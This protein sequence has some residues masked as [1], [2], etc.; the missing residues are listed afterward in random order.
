MFSFKNIDSLRS[1]PTPF[2]YYDL[3]VLEENILE[4]EKH[5]RKHQVKIH[6]AL[7]A[8]NNRPILK[9]MINAGFGA[10]CVSGPEMERAIESGFLPMDIVFAGVGKTDDEIRFGIHNQISCFNCESVH[11]LEIIDQIAGEMNSIA[12]VALRINPDFNGQTHKKITTGT[13]F[14]KFGIPKDEILGTIN[15]LKE[16]KNIKFNGLHFHIGSQIVN[17][18]IFAALAREINQIQDIFIQH[19]LIPPVLNL[20]GGLG[21]DY[22]LP[23]SN[24]IPDYSAFFDAY[25]NNLNR[26]P[27]QEIHFELG[28]SIVAECGSLISKVLFLKKN[29]AATYAIV[30][31]GMNDLMR[32]ALYNAKHKIQNLTGIGL[33]E[34]YHVAG[35]VC[36]SSDVF[37]KDILLP[38]LNRGDLIAI[39]TSGA[40]GEVMASGYNLRKPA[41][42]FYS[43]ELQ[44]LFPQNKVVVL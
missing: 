9:K 31:A 37:R 25:L 13:R 30:D 2:Y 16:L 36:E 42:A 35:P 5:S 44:S 43:K 20:G 32:P 14:D 24:P 39:R 6:Y 18:N 10:D 28:R 29:A 12:P 3:D 15:T 19:Y 41:R 33:E 21:V 38:Q 11:E 40:Y 1:L 4:L 7:K 23:D 22:E 27:N 8:N 34:I 26:L 17:M